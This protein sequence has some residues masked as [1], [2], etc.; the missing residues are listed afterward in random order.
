MCSSD[1]MGALPQFKAINAQSWK[2]IKDQAPDELKNEMK[3]YNSFYDWQQGTRIKY[4]ELAT[5]EA[6]ERGVDPALIPGAVEKAIQQSPIYKA[7]ANA[8]NYYETK[9]VTEHPQEAYDLWV[10]ER[11]KTKPSWLP[12]KEQQAIILQGI[13]R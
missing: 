4:T 1:L 10:E 3:D 5:K 11:K 9:W 6:E 12:T 13:K 7:Q 8:R 2:A